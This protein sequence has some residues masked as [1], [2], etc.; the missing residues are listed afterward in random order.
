[1]F[2]HFYHQTIRKVVVAFG[3]IFN[4]IYISRLDNSNTE[5]ERIKVPI[6]YGPQQKFIR[7]LSRIGTDFDANKVKSRIRG[8]LMERSHCLICINVF[9]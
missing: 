8:R 3:S 4:D 2:E 1:M 9:M 5:V 6:G 7:R